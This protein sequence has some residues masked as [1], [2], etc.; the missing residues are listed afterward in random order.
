MCDLSNTFSRL[1]APP[2]K[3]WVPLNEFDRML[4]EVLITHYAGSLQSSPLLYDKM[5]K[6]RE[7]VGSRGFEIG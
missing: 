3:D 7:F 1:A 2:R 4:N 5:S 6:A